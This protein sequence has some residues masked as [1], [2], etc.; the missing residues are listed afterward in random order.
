[1]F[2]PTEWHLVFHQ[3]GGRGERRETMAAKKKPP[4]ARRGGSFQKRLRYGSLL[5]HSSPHALKPGRGTQNVSPQPAER[6][7]GNGWHFGLF[8]AH[9]GAEDVPEFLSDTSYCSF[10]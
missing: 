5:G 3:P 10:S 2:I 7:K 4:A 8:S 9:T 6:A 1:M